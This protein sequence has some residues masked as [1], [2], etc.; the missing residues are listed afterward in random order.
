MDRFVTSVDDF[1]GYLRAR[2]EGSLLEGA[3]V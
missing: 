1:G 2:D 3:D